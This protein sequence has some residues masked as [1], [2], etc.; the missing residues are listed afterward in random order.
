M[1]STT[2]SPLPSLLALTH[3]SSREG[4]R[5]GAESLWF[6]ALSPVPSTSLASLKPTDSI[7]PVWPVFSHIWAYSG[8]RA[9]TGVACKGSP[10]SSAWSAISTVSFSPSSSKSI[11]ACKCIHTWMHTYMR[12]R[13]HTCIHK[14][15]HTIHLCIH[16]CMSI[17]LFLYSTYFFFFLQLHLQHIEVP[18]LGVKSELQLQACTTATTPPNLSHIFD[19]GHNLQQHQILNTLRETRDQMHILTDTMLGC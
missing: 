1:A 5:T 2:Y 17:V 11:Y 16:I 19:L 15:V 12:T 9:T 13:I 10:C 18:R 7:P 4:T 6:W 14:Y 8:H 3:P